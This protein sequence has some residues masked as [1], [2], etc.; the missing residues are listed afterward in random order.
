MAGEINWVR[1]VYKFELCLKES[2]II[3]RCLY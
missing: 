3:E 2:G 1:A